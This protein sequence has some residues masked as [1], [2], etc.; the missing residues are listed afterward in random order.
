MST[1]SRRSA[2]AASPASSFLGP[3]D[4]RAALAGAQSSASGSVRRLRPLAV[5]LELPIAVPADL[6]CDFGPRRTFMLDTK[7]LNR[8]AEQR[9]VP[10]PQDQMVSRPEKTHLSPV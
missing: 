4:A 1:A 9:V 5:V 7:V 6:L 8:T 3:D 10:L 2:Y